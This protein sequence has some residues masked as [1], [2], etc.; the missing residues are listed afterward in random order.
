M[1]FMGAIAMLGLGYA[2]VPLYDLFCRVTG[3]GGTTQR[4]TESEADLAAAGDAVE[5][6][7]EHLAAPWMDAR[8]KSGSIRHLKL[9]V[10]F[11]VLFNNGQQGME[12]LIRH[13]LAKVCRQGF[14]ESPI[15]DGSHRRLYSILAS[16]IIIR[17]VF[18]CFTLAHVVHSILDHFSRSEEGKM[19]QRSGSFSRELQVG[20]AVHG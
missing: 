13:G 12:G 2:A 18:C 8:R 16:T 6:R 20:R 1:A 9:V 11:E 14:V 15:T 3:F 17:I 10:S 7:Y 4:A 5:I 19:L